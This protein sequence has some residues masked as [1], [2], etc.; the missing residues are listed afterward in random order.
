MKARLN[1]HVV[2]VVRVLALILIASFMLVLAKTTILPDEVLSPLL[3]ASAMVL[4]L[5]A[6]SHLARRILFPDIDL[7]KLVDSIEASDNQI[8]KGLVFIGVCW[9]L[10][11][12]CQSFVAMLR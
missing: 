3:T 7:R 11:I 5:V 12:L 1:H 9:I 10:G 8:A 4:F 2:D 6:F